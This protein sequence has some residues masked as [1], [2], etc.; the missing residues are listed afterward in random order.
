MI[1]LYAIRW[2]IIPVCFII[3]DVYSEYLI[4]VVP[5]RWIKTNLPGALTSGGVSNI[6]F[7]FRG[8]NAVREAIHSAFLYHAI[9]AGLDMAIVNP[10][11]LQI[12]EDIEPELLTC[13]EDVIFNKDPHATERLIEK[14]SQMLAAKEAISKSIYTFTITE[15]TIEAWESIDN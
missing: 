13:V 6:S 1:S 12:Y 10:S 4:K 9:Q 7:A 5:V 14:A 15:E 2:H 8:N 11:M 3:N